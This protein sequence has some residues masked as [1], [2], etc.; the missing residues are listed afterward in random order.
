MLAPHF[1][2][3]PKRLIG[4]YLDHQM[5]DVNK[6]LEPLA[7]RGRNQHIRT[8]VRTMDDLHHQRKDGDRKKATDQLRDFIHQELSPRPCKNC[9]KLYLLS[10][11]S[12]LES[13]DIPII[14]NC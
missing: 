12:P 8:M 1:K 9:I 7:H 11:F 6:I 2:A 14:E 4:L 13:K 10:A 3:I 5:A